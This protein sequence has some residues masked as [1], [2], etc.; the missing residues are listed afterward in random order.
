MSGLVNALGAHFPFWGW[1]FGGLEFWLV[2]IERVWVI[3]ICFFLGK[4]R[5]QLFGGGAALFLWEFYFQW[6]NW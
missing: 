6:F 2:V 4:F 5:E 3:R 1:G